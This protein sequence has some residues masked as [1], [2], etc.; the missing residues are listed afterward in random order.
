MVDKIRYFIFKNDSFFS[1]I[2]LLIFFIEQLILIILVFYFKVN[3]ELLQLIISVFALIVVTTSS[4]QKL[5]LDIR[6]RHFKEQTIG[7]SKLF[8]QSQKMLGN[9]KELI[10]HLKEENLKEK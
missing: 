6:V 7:F 4:F 2:F 8:F 1:I 5:I 9:F 3:I 10:K